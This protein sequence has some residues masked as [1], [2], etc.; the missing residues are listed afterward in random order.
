ML[1]SFDLGV[2]IPVAERTPVVEGLLRVIRAQWESLEAER[3][4]SLRL[5]LQVEALTEE[6]N[7]LKGLP[8]KPKRSRQPSA[9]NDPRGKPSENEPQGQSEE[10]AAGAADEKKQGEGSDQKRSAGKRAGSAKRSKTREIVIHHTVPLTLSGLPEGT[11]RLWDAKV[12]GA[13]SAN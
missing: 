3:E 8:E 7:R 9:L 4:K 12:C 10:A 13:G 11:G 2:E 5:Q 6:V 1:E